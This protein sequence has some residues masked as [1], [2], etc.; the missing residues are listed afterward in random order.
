VIDEATRERLIAADPRSAEVIKPFLAGREIKRYLA[1]SPTKYLILFEKGWTNRNSEGVSDKWG[2]LKSAYPPVAAHLEPFAEKGERR[3]DKGDYWWEL[4]ACNY[5]REFEK[6][7]IIYPN[8]CKKPEFTYD[9][10]N[11]YSNQK[12]FVITI[13]D[14]YLLGILNSKLSYFLFRMMLPKLRGD[15]YEPS[16]VIFKD[17]PI[18]VPDNANPADVTRRDR[19]GAL[20]EQMLDLNKRLAA[21]KTAHEKEVLAGMVDATDRQIDRLVYELYGLT[22]EEVAVVE[23]V[24]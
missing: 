4:R 24:V 21:A 19:I 20:V 16:Y 18:C 23:G 15:F 17:F 22:E 6:P 2:W 11:N 3:C 13:T 10:A 12:C 8:I 7:K 1:P 9:E 5:Y 14:K